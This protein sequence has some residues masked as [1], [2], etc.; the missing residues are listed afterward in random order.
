MTG[1]GHSTNQLSPYDITGCWRRGLTVVHPVQTWLSKDLPGFSPSAEGNGGIAQANSHFGPVAA[2]KI[3]SI[4]SDASKHLE[5]W[6]GVLR[7]D[8]ALPAG[9]SFS[10]LER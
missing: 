4:H 2:H 9:R 3:S 1:L 6:V 5:P 7:E 8:G 10:C